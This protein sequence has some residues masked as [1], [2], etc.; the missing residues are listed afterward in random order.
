MEKCKISLGGLSDLQFELCGIKINLEV[1]EVSQN[2]NLLY[3]VKFRQ[4][5]YQISIVRYVRTYKILT[6]VLLKVNVTLTI[7]NKWL[8]TWISVS[9]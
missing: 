3:T 7:Q 9:R 2:N 5:N 6:H 1:Y 4:L 8:A